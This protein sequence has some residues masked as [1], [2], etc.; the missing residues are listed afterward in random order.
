[1]SVEIGS[2]GGWGDKGQEYRP[3][4]CQHQLGDGC[5]WC[6]QQCNLDHHFCPGCGTVTGHRETACP[7]CA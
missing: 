1:M 6:C 4:R 2:Y 7:D 3:D 5:M